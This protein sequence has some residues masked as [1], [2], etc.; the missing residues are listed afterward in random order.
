M[1]LH[2]GYYADVAAGETPVEY[3]MISPSGWTMMW[4]ATAAGSASEKDR[5]DMGNFGLKFFSSRDLRNV[6]KFSSERAI[7][8][9]IRYAEQ[10]FALSTSR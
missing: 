8:S 6:C 2:R 5:L 1:T 9:K 4:T 7:I 3:S 10:M